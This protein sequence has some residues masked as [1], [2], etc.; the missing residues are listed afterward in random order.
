MGIKETLQ[1][2]EPIKHR[3]NEPLFE[4]ADQMIETYD[5]MGDV[6]FDFQYII[7]GWLLEIARREK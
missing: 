6:F 2:L 5:T 3:L 4:E 7:A 1:K